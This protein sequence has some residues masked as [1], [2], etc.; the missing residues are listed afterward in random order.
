MN[1]Q[2]PDTRVRSVWPTPPEGCCYVE[3][4]LKGGDYISTGYFHRGTVDSKGRG[5]S[6]ENCQGV[7][8]L[9]FDLDLLGLVDA[10]R[11]AR[12]QAL[13]DKAADRKAHMY[14]M[15][16]EQRQQW[17]DLLLQDVGGILES[18]MGAPPTLTICSGWGYHFHYAVSEPMRTEKAALQS[19]HAAVVDECN[20][21]ASEVGQTLHPPL[22]TYH[23]AF[24]RTHDVGARLARAPGSQNTKCAWRMSSVD[25]IAASDTVLD[26]DTVGRLRAQW[27]RQGQLTDNDKAR[28]KGSPVPSRKRPRQ[29]KSVDV[30]FRAQ[31]LADGRSWQQLADA[32]APGERLKVICPF[33][34]TSVGSG[35]FHREQDG[36]V[37]YY[38]SMQA[39]TYWNSYRPSTT[40][41]LVDLRR[42]PP[43]KDGTQ[44]RI[45]N[46]VTNLHTMLT[47]DAAF[48][49]W[50]D[51][52]RQ[53]EMD[54]HDVIDDGIWVR[55]I[56]HME[57]AYDWQWR[58]G[59]ELLFSA[60][61]FVCR[62]SSRNPVQEYVKAL[63]WDGCP[64]IDRWLLEVCNT[65]DLPIYR[66]YAR[67]WV[68]GLM[69]RLF[70]PGCQLH[71]CMLLTG[72]Q[73]WGK[74]SVWR[75]W[76]NWPGQTEL[77]SD[78]R[79]NIKDKDCYLQL[80]SALIYEDAEMAGSS[81]ADQET[82]KAF[83]TSAVDR[84]R[85]PFGRKMRTYRRHTVITMT[86]N[87]QDVLRDRTGS[88][89]YWVVPCSG[90]SAGLR[91]LGKY[92]DQML[93]EAYEEYQKGQQ[94][95]LTP[96]ESK[97]QRKANGVFQYHDWF[98]QCALTAWDANGAGRRN[99]FTVAEFAA[100]IDQN[101]SVQ[102]F[103]LSLSSA[104]HAAGF[105]RYRSGGA[106]YY[107]KTGDST[108]SATGLLAIR[109]L[110]RTSHEQQA[111]L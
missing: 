100:A 106:T 74:S 4:S 13:P 70:S 91:W 35:F 36:R 73:G 109:G 26:S 53:Q 20:R 68:L 94:W 60:V 6:V 43:K 11:L 55:V 31:R 39:V 7:T 90:E 18:V 27:E 67:K 61:E 34:G 65:E 17:L 49:L 38:S 79:F 40:P 87:E 72:P 101:L 2:H 14:Q 95:W 89:R 110:T 99:R 103:G 16:E 86:S 108:G 23:K 21:Q 47:H 28:A 84:F 96:D 85:P 105:T 83:I 63:K 111:G 10:A 58:V 75:E 37:R 51:E 30:D 42:S 69:A 25:I 92:R 62:Q 8:S 97:M 102:R 104:L 29:A 81:N 56:T 78:T 22:T 77:Y 45:L 82:R 66:V 76:A 50:F 9:F 15:P 71:T 107:Y 88:R 12:G 41:G 46:S 24:D 80:Y 98:S 33:G 32:L 52:F 64:R 19:L 93:A 59:K 3:Q 5:R 44:G 1:A 48:S 57:S 54:G